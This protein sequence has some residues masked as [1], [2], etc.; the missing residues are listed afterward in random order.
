M[1]AN[2]T[3]TIEWAVRQW[4]SSRSELSHATLGA[5]EGEVARL[6]EYAA[7]CSVFTVSSLTPELWQQYLAALCIDRSAVDTRRKSSLKPS[8][9]Q[10]AG[11]ITRGF[12]R[13]CAQRGWLSWV[14]DYSSYRHPVV[15]KQPADGALPLGL[16][17]ILLDPGTG[18]DEATARRRCVA[19]L[20]F[21]CGLTPQEIAALRYGHLKKRNHGPWILLASGRAN[22][23]AMPHVLVLQLKRYAMVRPQTG[24][25]NDEP[26]IC[27]LG[28]LLP[29]TSSA[30]WRLLRAWPLPR[31]PQTVGVPLGSRLL[32]NGFLR[33]ASAEAAAQL[34][35]VARQAGRRV[36]PQLLYSN[37]PREVEV[38]FQAVHASLS[39]ATNETQ[40][41]DDYS[42]RHN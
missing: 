36:S 15:P 1:T 26:L 21:W 25:Q 17:D 41:N 28:S 20:A 4:L 39:H 42:R 8:S 5:Y 19:G 14:P 38:V 9:A 34:T 24:E 18:D 3:P 29:L 22:P 10:Q 6:S 30:V 12:L 7:K 40:Q 11:R 33:L 32:R 2:R 13:Y 16:S 27:R 23:L 35:T 31:E 37:D